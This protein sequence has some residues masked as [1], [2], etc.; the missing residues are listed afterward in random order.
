MQRLFLV[1][2]ILVCTMPLTACAQMAAF[3]EEEIPVQEVA[4]E[5]VPA[6]LGSFSYAEDADIYQPGEA[7]VNP[8]AFKNT[9]VCPIEDQA[10]AVT[11][12]K[13]ECTINYTTTSVYLDN[14]AGVWR[15]DFLNLTRD[16]QGV[17]TVSDDWQKVYLGS[18]GITALIVYSASQ[19]VGTIA[20][21]PDWTAD[22]LELGDID[23]TTS[24][25]ENTVTEIGKDDFCRSVELSTNDVGVIEEIINNGTWIVAT[26]KCIMNCA[27]NLEGR[28]YYYHSDCGTLEE[29]DLS[30]MSYLSSMTAEDCNRSLRLTEDEKD[31]VN[32]ILER[33]I[34]IGME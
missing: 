20:T 27:I 11:R 25:I 4:L 7:G 8:V 16:E 9:D 18:D 13:N 15:V 12:A 29:M 22:A 23:A 19:S 32:S 5:K 31:K 28:L 33:Y 17:L 2:T 21:S 24:T 1:L 34:N 10:S 3:E 6:S 14:E 30:K 26:P